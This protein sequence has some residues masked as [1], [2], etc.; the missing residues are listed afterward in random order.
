MARIKNVSGE[1]RFA[2]SWADGRLVLEGEVID[3]PDE[4][5]D[6]LDWSAGLFAVVAPDKKNT[7]TEKGDA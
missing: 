1:P 4:V 3:V 5:A 2:G 7:N 6:A